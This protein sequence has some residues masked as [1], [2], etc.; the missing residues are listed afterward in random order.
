MQKGRSS[1][2][3][4]G[5]RGKKGLSRSFFLALCLTAAAATAQPQSSENTL[6][7]R[8]ATAWLNKIHRAAQREN[9]VGT[10]IYQRGSVMHASRI[11]HYSD[12][13]NNEY[14]RLE[15]LDGKPREVLRQNDV[16]HSLIPE[17]KLVVVEKQ[18]A[19]D[20]F[21]ALLATNKG[22]VL[23]LYDM[24]K[25]AAE[26]VAGVEC[27]VFA[28]EPHDTARYAVRLWAD[29]NSGLLM[30]A[31]TLGEGGKVLEQVAFSQVDIGVPSDKQRILSAIK[32][33]GSWNRYEVTYQP[34]NIADEGWTIHTPLKGFQKI[35]EVRRPLGELR[36]P[37][38]GNKPGA[39][40]EV[41][42]IV[43]SDGLT[44]LSVF[45]EPVSEQRARREGV[46]S[47]GATQV[48][49]R[50]VNDFW[51]TVVG[52]VPAATVKQF[53]AGVEYRPPKVH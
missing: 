5:V 46:A 17:A 49:V 48:V 22:D 27:E 31:Q 19:K 21:P 1:A 26:R 35:R 12:L 52:E 8:D 2:N 20:R 43:Y 30:R 23:D 9:Y 14:E 51:V 11:Q 45:I 28:L 32:G 41:L 50:R 4:A 37:A 15:T 29:R 24:R 25:L 33:A 10:L 39:V 40:F 53:A 42:Q 36:A 7:R 16:V 44:G 47:L 13:T 18:E 3:G 38:Q 6:N 34:A